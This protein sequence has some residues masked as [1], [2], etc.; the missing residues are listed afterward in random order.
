MVVSGL[1]ESNQRLFDVCI[2]LQSNA[3]PTEL[4]P[5]FALGGFDPPTFRLWAGHASSAPQSI[6]TLFSRSFSV[7]RKSVTKSCDWFCDFAPLF[8]KVVLLFLAA[9]FYKRK[10]VFYIVVAVSSR[11]IFAPMYRRVSGNLG[12]LS[13]KNGHRSRGLGR[14]KAALCHL[15][16]LDKSSFSCYAETS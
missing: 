13:I 15:S 2:P 14:V 8:P 1:P 16:Y 7:A 10:S 12:F 6:D 4:K 3:L 11:V 5:E 9:I